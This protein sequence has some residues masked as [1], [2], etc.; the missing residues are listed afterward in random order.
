M[1]LH[2]R[3]TAGA[4]FDVD[5]DNDALVEDLMVLVEVHAGIA[6]DAQHLL[7]GAVELTPRGRTVASFG[8]SANS[9]VTVQTKAE[10]E[11]LQQQI[12]RLF[13][14]GAPPRAPI[15]PPLTISDPN[16]LIA[17]LFRT[18][19]VSA[20]PPPPALPPNPNDPEVQRRLYEQIEKENLEQN[21]VQALEH[22]PEA[23][24]R[25]TMLYVPC[26]V[27]R[28][29]VTAFVDSGAQMS[30]MNEATAERCG[31]M[32]LLD[33]RMQGTAVGVGSSKILGRIHMTLVNLGGLHL[34]ISITVLENQS[35][36]FLLGL[37]Q[38]RRH[39]MHIDLKENCLR[40]QETSIPFLSE[41]ELPKHLRDHQPESP[42]SPATA[43]GPSQQASSTATELTRK[44][45]ILHVIE[46]ARVTRDVAIRTLEAVNWS[47]DEAISALLG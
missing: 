43:G 21:L 28:V 8:V 22:T 40:I 25:V 9:T 3:T 18:E 20:P 15:P 13:A 38:L 16:A 19:A 11:G 44:K 41:G 39:Q 36:E 10:E 17:A 47:E 32:R 12:Q 33:R 30:I 1:R 34:P 42:M 14:R 24:G 29:P 27:N 35:M 45:K 7:L 37:D 6:M 31:I 46:V 23:F 5:V 26:S 4:T 2:C